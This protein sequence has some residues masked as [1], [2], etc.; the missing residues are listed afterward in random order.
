MKKIIS[1]L[2]KTL[3]VILVVLLSANVMTAK[4]FAEVEEVVPQPET[5]TEVAPTETIVEETTPSEDVASEDETPAAI[6]EVVEEIVSETETITE[7][8]KEET[9]QSEEIKET[10]PIVEELLDVEVDNT[11]TENS[12]ETTIDQEQYQQKLMDI[13]QKSIDEAP[14]EVK[15]AIAEQ[16]ANAQENTE[17]TKEELETTLPA[18][19]LPKLMSMPLMA[20]GP[21]T[22]NVEVYA[23]YHSNYP[24]G[25]NAN[26]YQEKVNGNYSLLAATNNK[27]K[28]SCVG[29]S[30]SSWNTSEDGQ[31]TTLSSGKFESSFDL[32]AQW[33]ANTYIITLNQTSATT[34]GTES[35]NVTYDGDLANTITVPQRNEYTFDGFYTSATDGIKVIDNTGKLV[36]D[37]KDYTDANK[38]W[39][40]AGDVTLHPQWTPGSP[41][42][43]TVTFSNDGSGTVKDE[44]PTDVTSVSDITSGTSYTI[45]GATITIGDKTVTATPTDGESYEFDKWTNGTD[46]TA[47]TGSGTISGNTTF[48]ANFKAKSTTKYTVTFSNDG[49]GTVKNETPTDVTSVSD[50]TSG[51]SYTISGATITIDG[52]TYTATP[53]DSTTKE[54]DKWTNGFNDTALTGTSTITADTAFKAN[55]KDISTTTYTV[56]IDLNG[57][58]ITEGDPTANG[59]ALTSGTYTKD[60]G[61]NV[62]I[63]SSILSEWSSITISK[64]GVSFAGWSYTGTELTSDLTITA[65]W[66]SATPFEAAVYYTIEAAGGNGAYKGI[67][68]WSDK[69]GN[70]YLSF[71]TAEKNTKTVGSATVGSSNASIEADNVG[72]LTVIDANDKSKC[73][74]NSSDYKFI[75]IKS[76]NES[77]KGTM[78]FTVVFEHGGGFNINDGVITIAELENSKYTIKYYYANGTTLIEDEMFDETSVSKVTEYTKATPTFNMP[79]VKS[80]DG[81]TFSWY[82][83][84]VTIDKVT[85]GSSGDMK[86][87]G[88]WTPL[89]ENNQPESEQTIP[90]DNNLTVDVT[91][92]YSEDTTLI[93]SATIDKP[94]FSQALALLDLIGKRTAYE[95]MGKDVEIN[96]YIDNPQ[97]AQGEACYSKLHEHDDDNTGFVFSA[98]IKVTVEGDA[99]YGSGKTINN[100]GYAIPITITVPKTSTKVQTIVGPNK[101]YMVGRVHDYGSGNIYEEWE[102][103]LTED[104]LNYYFTFSSQYFSDFVI[105]SVDVHS[106]GYTIPITGIG[107]LSV[108]IPVLEQ[109]GS[110]YGSCI[111]MS[112]EVVL[113]GISSTVATLYGNYVKPIIAMFTYNSYQRR[114]VRE[115]I[116]NKKFESRLFI[117]GI[118][119]KIVNKLLSIKLALS[120]LVKA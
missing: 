13:V 1:L 82:Y 54:F 117:T 14:Q 4:V 111:D 96:L 55:F 15:D 92:S 108:S 99:E 46:D 30:F 66:S 16:Q 2:L 8:P 33:T 74:Y 98:T 59:W 101:R 62:S 73:Y 64:S 93:S 80:K 81:Y 89:G 9:V 102:A 39:I 90:D 12:E 5:I 21:L 113:A 35:V 94:N 65:Q 36:A 41:T 28:Y 27:L 104:A 10:Q 32:Y 58:T 40:K 45:S 115:K 83:N 23:T 70:I 25:N 56:T 78:S 86:I 84:G 72:S 6:E 100:A 76:S 112:Q 105:Y 24:H 77:L 42:F 50:I 60:F 20:S 118:R 34:D 116:K 61:D 22:A 75:V 106:S 67:G 69:S 88:I 19:T 44:T 47:L 26:P 97:I 31:G 29:Y 87:I 38:K 43:Y 52:T 63:S 18:L 11:P 17:T 103:T 119:N 79:E 71:Y 107:T 37:V 48:K 120:K 3:E 49:S 85:I 53:N 109:A 68:A 91:N 51:T 110:I 95:Q 114:K 7:V 57:G